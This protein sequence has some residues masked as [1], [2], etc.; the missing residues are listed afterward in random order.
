MSVDKETQEASVIFNETLNGKAAVELLHKQEYFGNVLELELAPAVAHDQMDNWTYNRSSYLEVTFNAP[1][2]RVQATY[3]DLEYATKKAKALN[4]HA[5]GGRI[6]SATVARKPTQRENWTYIK[7]SI[8]IS[9][10]AVDTPDSEILR[11]AE[12][13]SIKVFNLREF[14]VN[15]VLRRLRAHMRT[16]GGLKPKDFNSITNDQTGVILVRGRFDNWEEA[17]RV[18]QSLQNTE[19]EFLAPVGARFFLA[20]PHQY[21]LHVPL[22]HYHAQKEIYDGM[23]SQHGSDRTA[24]ITVTKYKSACLVQVVGTDKEAVGALKLKVEKTARGEI[25]EVWDRF[26]LD[27]QGEAFFG[28]LLR[29]FKAYVRPDRSIQVLRVYGSE[30]AVNHA[31]IEIEEQM[32]ALA[33]LD[34]HMPIK[35]NLVGFFISQG[36]KILSDMLGEYNVW[37]HTAYKPYFISVRGGHD[38]EHALRQLMNEASGKPLRPP[39]LDTSQTCPQ[40]FEGPTQPFPLA[41]GHIYC[42]GCLNHILISATDGNTIPL[43]CTGGEGQCK[44]PIPLPVIERFISPARLTKMFE[45]SFRVYLEQRPNEFKSCPTP[46]CTIIYRVSKETSVVIQCPRCLTETCSHCHKSPHPGL[47]C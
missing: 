39:T 23:E 3:P 13:F 26:F 21:S 9:N 44:T 31:R 7:N 47:T 16:V 6:V 36:T 37:L 32:K 29:K 19:L 28:R 34:F 20:F 45:N 40:C 1:S 35:D 22:E 41:C 38:A 17:D 18:Y 8:I 25:V 33:G 27:R 43:F 14:S 15:T 24:H 46:S 4:G 11:F 42:I 10:V 30:T 2:K 5:C 12:P